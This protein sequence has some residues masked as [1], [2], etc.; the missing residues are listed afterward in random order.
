VTADEYGF[1]D[2]PTCAGSGLVTEQE[3]DE[4]VAGRELVES[5]PADRLNPWHTVTLDS[6]WHLAHPVTCDLSACP[7]DAVAR[8]W[9]GAPRS[10][11]IYRWYHTAGPLELVDDAPHPERGC[12]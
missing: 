1:V 6:G 10:E 3:Y 9:S 7:F 8:S 11:G 4:A 5:I 12:V 2:C